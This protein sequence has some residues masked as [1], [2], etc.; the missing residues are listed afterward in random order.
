[1]KISI[2]NLIIVSVVVIMV[3]VIAAAIVQ[4][5]RQA[6]APGTKVT[7]IDPNDPIYGPTRPNTTMPPAGDGSTMDISE[8]EIPVAVDVEYEEGVEPLTARDLPADIVGVKLSQVIEGQAA[9][10]AISKLHG[11]EITVSDGLVAKYG[12]K[13][14]GI[15]LWFSTS[16]TVDEATQLLRAMIEK[17]EDNE[18]YST[19]VPMPI[20]K[21]IF[22]QTIGHDLMHFFWQ[23]GRQLVWITL[24]L[25]QE[26]LMPAM[27]EVVGL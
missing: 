15:E 20:R 22:Y 13:G 24:D 14:E 26:Q 3:G 17:M 5:N 11:K 19:P 8:A 9:I 25:P 7:Q 21:R 18:I 6:A 1:M 4:T 10:E 23:R 12:Q 16:P 27:K 2:R